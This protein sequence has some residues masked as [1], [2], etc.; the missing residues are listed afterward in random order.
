MQGDAAVLEVLNDVVFTQV[1][2]AA[3]DDDK[4]AELGRRV[5]A[6]GTAA[7]TP[8]LW[9]GRPVQRVSVSSWATSEADVHRTVDAV[10]RVAA[11]L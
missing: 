2:L 4:T 9:R 5:L 3:W 11:S 6:E 8:A 1:M 10:R 7:F